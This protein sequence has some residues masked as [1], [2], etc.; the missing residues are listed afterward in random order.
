MNS[1]FLEDFQVSFLGSL[2][3]EDLLESFLN[4]KKIEN[5]E[6]RKTFKEVLSKRHA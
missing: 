5:K 4:R 6:N 3:L 2:L 1:K